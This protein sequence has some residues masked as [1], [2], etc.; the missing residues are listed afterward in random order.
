VTLAGA[1]W[2][3][4]IRYPATAPLAL[5]RPFATAD[6]TGSTSS[7]KTV[8]DGD[9]VLERNVEY[10]SLSILGRITNPNRVTGWRVFDSDVFGQQIAKTNGETSN[11][12]FWHAYDA[13]D[14]E[15]LLSQVTFRPA[16]PCI[17]WGG[18]VYG[19]MQLTTDR[20][21]IVHVVDGWHP[22]GRMAGGKT[23]DRGSFCDRLAWFSPT[24]SSNASHDSHS[25]CIQD[26]GPGELDFMYSTLLGF[27]SMPG[28]PDGYVG[29]GDLTAPPSPA[30]PD[31]GPPQSPYN[32]NRR[33]GTAN[34][35]VQLT[36][37]LGPA[38]AKSFRFCHFDGGAATL[39]L[40]AT[41][42]TGSAIE[43]NTFGHGQSLGDTY[44]ILGGGPNVSVA[45][46][47]F[48]DTGLPARWRS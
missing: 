48:L 14:L 30:D 21:K 37:N 23:T 38:G 15:G 29:N 20:I 8:H 22:V 44:C 9:L 1:A 43:D 36:A 18:L 31:L 27:R 26:Q 45:R 19:A 13:P 33:F 11:G 35:A 42:P 39:N 10:E 4:Q 2:V 3:N 24:K 28:D 47:T 41:M 5:P 40:A 16:F 32:P 7:R 6:N 12:L 46:N 34:S 17:D 25:D